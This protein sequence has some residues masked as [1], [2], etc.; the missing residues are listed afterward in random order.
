MVDRVL[1]E[2]PDKVKLVYYHFSLNPLSMKAAEA[3][4]CAG[5][6]G[7]FWEFHDML[8]QF[9]ASWSGQQKYMEYFRPYAQQ[10][11]LNVEQ[12]SQCVESGKMREVAQREKSQGEAL[13][14][15][16]TPTIFLNNIRIVGAQP[17]IVYAQTI[18]E[19]LKK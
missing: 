14:I 19:L 9:Q 12:F 13:N 10:L 16:S 4:L 6:Q 2:Y 3:A 15:N 7:K 1:Q 17:Y 11:G 5:A 8:F 18:E